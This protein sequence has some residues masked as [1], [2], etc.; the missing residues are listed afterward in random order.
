MRQAV[1][2]VVDGCLSAP[3][4]EALSLV[5]G[6]RVLPEPRVNRV[7][8]DRFGAVLGAPDG[9]FADAGLVYEV[10]G[11]SVHNGLLDLERDERRRS[12]F[13]AA[14]LLVSD[15]SPRRLRE[16]GC[17]WLRELEAAYLHGRE[18]GAMPHILDHGPLRP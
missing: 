14:G 7:L 16:D 2:D 3:E 8:G 10:N 1:V 13:L 12:R 15:V 18:R 5:R 4:A 9:W 11:R 17:G 6:S